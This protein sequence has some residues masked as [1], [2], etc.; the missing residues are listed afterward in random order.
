MSPAV[1]AAKRS[2]AAHGRRRRA[3]F[4]DVN[5]VCVSHVTLHVLAV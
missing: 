5:P 3:A 4:Y 1:T 2:L